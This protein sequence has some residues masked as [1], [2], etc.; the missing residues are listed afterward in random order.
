MNTEQKA[1]M[2]DA[3]KTAD[4]LIMR[5]RIGSVTFEVAA[6]FSRASQETIADKVVRMAEREVQKSA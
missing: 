3:D 5:T 2:P 4:P 6:R 1:V